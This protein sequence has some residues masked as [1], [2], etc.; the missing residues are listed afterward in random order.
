MSPTR[1][2]ACFSKAANKLRNFGTVQFGKRA[3]NEVKV[4]GRKERL[5]RAGELDE[6]NR[7]R[8]TPTVKLIS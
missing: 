2:L 6:P 4:V 5:E 3:E 8:T 1:S 7:P